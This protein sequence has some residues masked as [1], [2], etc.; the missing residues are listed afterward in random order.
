VGLLRPVDDADLDVLFEHWTDPESNRMAAFTVA[1]PHDRQAFTERWARLRSNPS[2]T[3]QTIVVDGEVAGSISSW[4]NEGVREVTY[5]LGR[6]HWGKGV[7]T[8]ALA[9]F[10]S[11]VETARPVQAAAVFDNVGSQRVLEKC[12]F[13]RIGEGRGFANGRGAEVDEVLFRLDA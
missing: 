3:A 9:E 13:R 12:G 1:D 5:W 6:D 7:A 2:V 8:R 11:E 4:D 10:L